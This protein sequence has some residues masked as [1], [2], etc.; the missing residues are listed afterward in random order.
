MI[1]G[2]EISLLRDAARDL[3]IGV[4]VVLEILIRDYERMQKSNQQMI[5][6]LQ[7]VMRRSELKWNEVVK[8]IEEGKAALE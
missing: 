3:P 6:V 4:K 2:I 7:K 8:A 1:S 5:E